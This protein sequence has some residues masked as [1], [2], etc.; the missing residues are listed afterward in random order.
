MSLLLPLGLLGLIGVA[1]LILIYIIKPNYQQKFVSSTY[2][3]KLS[4]KYKKKRIPVSK[5]RN[6]LL[7]LCQ[8]LL[9]IS[10]AFML[11][12]PVIPFIAET[13]KDEKVAVIDAS[14]GMLLEDQGKTRFERAVEEV[15]VLASATLAKE[16]GAISVIL[17]GEKASVLVSRESEN[18][19][20]VERA[21]DAL[22]SETL[23]CTYGTADV[24]GAAALAEDILKQNSQTEVLFYTAT[25]YV[26][27]GSFTVVDVSAEAD[28]NVAIL[29]CTP[30]LEETNVYSFPV[31]V[32]CYGKTKPVT[33]TVEI[34]NANETTG[35]LRAEKTEYFSE[36]EPE[37]TLSFSSEDFPGGAGIVSYDYVYVTVNEEDSFRKDNT[38]S[39]YG[40][41]RPTVKI[42]YAS[43]LANNFFG[44]VFRTLRQTKK[45]QWS[46][47]YTSV[48]AADAKTE[49]YDLYVFEHNM[50]KVLPKDGVVLLVD[51]DKAPEG[52]DFTVG[53]TITVDSKSTL[54]SGEAHA[55]T[56]GLDASR[57]TVAQYKEILSPNGYT[58]LMYYE[59]NPVLLVNEE[60]DAPVVV[61]SVDL[62]KSNLA[63]MPDFPMFLF[64]LFDRYL[65]A[66]LS[67]A[68]F[69]VGEETTVTARG[70]D[71]TIEGPTGKTEYDESSASLSL[72][73]P[74]DYTVTQKNLKNELLIDR[75]F[76]HVP[77]S[78]SNITKQVDALPKI[79]TAPTTEQK[80]TDLLVYIAAGAL[81][82]LVIEWLLHSKENI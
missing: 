74:G 37:K 16:N 59:G 42:Q 49:G 66:T 19:E 11:A 73:V 8:A 65:P 26:D 29:G 12:K 18:L 75:F 22:T 40:G 60:G 78:E 13:P 80:N 77:A 23:A 20:E 38:F 71:L 33:V 79:Y 34:Y 28:W 82:L 69:E 2:I 58:E 48:S 55:L 32:G 45:A 21:L 68:A 6:I 56:R 36:A 10:F 51:P 41:T 57:I 67:K 35:V 15:K 4:L 50:P 5:L 17:A 27:K 24:D 46:I 43:S 47:E 72:S 52:A 25:T 39:V 14:A 3:W 54:A 70:T 9:L 44:G 30:V 64:N 81:A 53:K 63:L 62:R 31:T 61:L 1:A 7:F 76:V